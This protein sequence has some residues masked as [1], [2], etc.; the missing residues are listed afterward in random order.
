MKFFVFSF[1]FLLHYLSSGPKRR[2]TGEPRPRGNQRQFDG[3]FGGFSQNPSLNQKIKEEEEEKRGGGGRRESGKSASQV[4]PDAN[5][6]PCRL[7]PP[8][9][10]PSC[11]YRTSL[12]L[13]RISFLSFLHRASLPLLQILSPLRLDPPSTALLHPS[14]HSTVPPS[15]CGQPFF[16]HQPCSAPVP[17]LC[18]RS[19]CSAPDCL[20]SAMPVPL[21]LCPAAPLLALLHPSLHSAAPPALC[22]ASCTLCPTAG[23]DAPARPS[24][25]Q[26]STPLPPCTP[27]LTP[28]P[29]ALHS[30]CY[31]PIIASH[32][33]KTTNN[34]QMSILREIF[35]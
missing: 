2:I 22:R 26:H 34:G 24:H 12:P 1:F 4:K 8:R 29:A 31:S 33:E 27:R 5:K 21:L 10:E 35:F 20:H 18:T 6:A 28:N 32:A 3:F 14:L 11:P 16:L 25:H 13:H 19:P 23:N 9:P 7:Q 15:S 17:A 30:A